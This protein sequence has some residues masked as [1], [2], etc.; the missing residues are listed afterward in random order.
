VIL[1]ESKLPKRLWAEAM[2]YSVY[3]NNRLPHSTI[4]PKT[5]FEKWFEKLPQV[6]HLWNFGKEA[7][8]HISEDSHPSGSKLNARAVKSNLV[9]YCEKEGSYHFWRGTKVMISQDYRWVQY[10][11]GPA[12][13]I[14]SE[15]RNRN[16][17]I[18]TEVPEKPTVLQKTM[19]WMK[20]SFPD[21]NFEH[22]SETLQEDDTNKQLL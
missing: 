3:T 9:C 15:A 12:P 22:R 17:D 7:Y 11:T 4:G 14:S 18:P 10:A 5:L 19:E 1:L 21:F 16:P 2:N 8:I 20:E 6:S 13:L